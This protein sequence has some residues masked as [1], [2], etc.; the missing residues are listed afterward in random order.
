MIKLMSRTLPL[1]AL[2][3][4]SPSLAA[5]TAKIM[6]TFDGCEIGKKYE[7]FDGRTLECRSYR[8]HYAY[9]PDVMIVDS[10]TVIIDGDEYSAWVN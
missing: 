6:G 9:S 7:L 10:S 8:Y 5:D 3:A 1:C 4:A 2:L